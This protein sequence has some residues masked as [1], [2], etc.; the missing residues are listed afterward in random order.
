MSGGRY[1]RLAVFLL[2]KRTLG[3]TSQSNMSYIRTSAVHD[4]YGPKLRCVDLASSHP[5][6]PPSQTFGMVEYMIDTL[7]LFGFCCLPAPPN[8]RSFA[9]KMHRFCWT[10]PHP[11]TTRSRKVPY[12][13]CTC[14]RSDD[15]GS[16]ITQAYSIHQ[17]IYACIYRSILNPKP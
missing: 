4:I 6:T 11:K 13:A 16:L 7:L 1:L 8:T 3:P 17:A 12:E 15:R 5:P 10:N 2:L 14:L 9:G